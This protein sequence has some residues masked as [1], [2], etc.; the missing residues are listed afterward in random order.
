[1]VA[2][3]VVVIDELPDLFFQVTRH[4][5]VLQ[6]DSVFQRLMPRLDLALDLRMVSKPDEPNP[7][8]IRRLKRPKCF[9]DGRC[10]TSAP[11]GQIEGFA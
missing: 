9:D 1:M 8:L 10:L 11:S 3:V 7:P 6:Q 2:A 4:V 5:I